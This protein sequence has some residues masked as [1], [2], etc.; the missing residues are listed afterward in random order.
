[1]SP[2]NVP[3]IRPLGFF[4]PL[5]TKIFM[6]ILYMLQCPLFSSKAE[7]CYYG[8]STFSHNLK[9]TNLQSGMKGKKALKYKRLCPN[10]TSSF[11]INIRL[12]IAFSQL[13]G[14]TQVGVHFSDQ[15]AGSCTGGRHPVEVNH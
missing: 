7:I 2:I 8:N 9:R 10:S 15:F 1:M 14:S 3:S 6:L 5:S 12:S 4:Y 11:S 13:L